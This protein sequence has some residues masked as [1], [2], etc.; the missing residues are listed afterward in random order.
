MVWYD[1]FMNESNHWIL[2]ISATILFYLFLFVNHLNKIV[3][4]Q[5]TIWAYFTF[6]ILWLLSDRS[7]DE[8]IAFLTQKFSKAFLKTY[9]YVFLFWAI[10]TWVGGSADLM[11][12]Q[13]RNG[14]TAES[15]GYAIG[16]VIGMLLV[17][18]I[19]TYLIRLVLPFFKKVHDKANK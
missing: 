12:V 7:E 14:T 19:F 13:F 10:A 1:S 5:D 8:F 3:L 11:D 15:I 18:L 9:K 2:F 16:T 17:P 6:T 4:P